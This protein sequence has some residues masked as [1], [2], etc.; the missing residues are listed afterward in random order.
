MD[1]YAAST[2]KQG[3]AVLGLDRMPRNILIN[4]YVNDPSDEH[5]LTITTTNLNGTHNLSRSEGHNKDID[6]VAHTYSLTYRKYGTS[7]TWM[8]S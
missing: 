6:I 8:V 5:Y 2:L 1:M 4:R 7:R 3:P